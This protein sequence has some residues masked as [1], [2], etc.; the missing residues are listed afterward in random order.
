MKR[1]ELI[2]L[3]ASSQALFSAS[4]HQQTFQSDAKLMRGA[5]IKN[6]PIEITAGIQQLKKGNFRE[7]QGI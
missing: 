7:D 2:E 3:D 6:K 5:S 1:S 4:K